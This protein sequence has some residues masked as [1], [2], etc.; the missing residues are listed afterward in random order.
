ML[1]GLAIDKTGR[2]FVAAI[3]AGQVWRIDGGGTIQI[4]AGGLR[5]PSAVALGH[6]P[7]GFSEGH[8]YAVTFAG[9]V[10]ELRGAR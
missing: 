8:V 4:I 9:D 6:G 1:D 10:A 7:R 2:L 5:C 3:G